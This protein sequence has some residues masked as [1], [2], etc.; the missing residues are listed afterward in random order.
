MKFFSAVYSFIIYGFL[1]YLLL[2]FITSILNTA[3]SFNN[4]FLAGAIIFAGSGLFFAISHHVFASIESSLMN[5]IAGCTAFF[6]VLMIHF[7]I[8]PLF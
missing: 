8:I 3:H 4:S 6:L 7:Y 2:I 5:R 1:A